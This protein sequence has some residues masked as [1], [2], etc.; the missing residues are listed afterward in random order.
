MRHTCS[1][2]VAEG[3]GR[4]SW[5]ILSRTEKFFPQ[6][7]SRHCKRRPPLKASRKHE[8]RMALRDAVLA[9]TQLIIPLGGGECGGS[10]RPCAEGEAEGR[11]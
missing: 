10:P 5:A 1:S 2:C 9:A 7:L 4:R 8:K 11:C 6:I 3:V